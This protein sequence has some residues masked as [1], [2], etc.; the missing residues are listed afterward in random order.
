[1]KYDAPT[2]TSAVFKLDRPTLSNIFAFTVPPVL[3]EEVCRSVCAYG[4]SGKL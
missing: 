1:M 2:A 3:R 4:F